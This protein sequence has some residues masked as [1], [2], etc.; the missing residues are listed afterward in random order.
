MSQ[1]AQ[2]A[3]LSPDFKLDL[4]LRQT[5]YD[6]STCQKLLDEADGDP[7]TVIRAYHGKTNRPAAEDK[8]V[9]Q[10]IYGEI[11]GLMDGAASE[12]RKMA[13]EKAQQEA[14]LEGFAK[15]ARILAAITTLPEA[16]RGADGQSPTLSIQGDACEVE[17]GSRAQ[18][19]IVDSPRDVPTVDAGRCLMRVQPSASGSE[20]ESLA[21]EAKEAGAA[22]VLLDH[23]TALRASLP[24][25]SGAS[26]VKAAWPGAVIA[27]TV[28]TAGPSCLV[29]PVGEA[30]PATAL[31]AGRVLRARD[32][33]GALCV[34]PQA[35]YDKYMGWLRA[36]EEEGV[37]LL[38]CA[39]FYD[40]GTFLRF[41]VNTRQA[42]ISAP[43]IPTLRTMESRADFEAHASGGGVRVPP[44]VEAAVVRLGDKDETVQEY[45]IQLAATA[46]KALVLRG[47]QHI[48]LQT[49]RAPQALSTVRAST[50]LSS[51][52]QAPQPAAGQAGSSV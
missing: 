7:L 43:V 5:D 18:F 6:R 41:V 1:P 24:E 19:C 17:V 37:N 28:H 32:E 25:T 50:Q 16:L 12:H 31:E 52:Q 35:A 14:K 39:P 49:A 38:I 11:R 9:N 10:R 15:N 44:G 26:L 33:E 4:V 48:H 36:Q 40:I 2:D 23:S 34:C 13:T 46:A 45:S 27:C 47:V 8:S 3:A 21:L 30:G 42:G 22:G 20:V 29:A 51:S